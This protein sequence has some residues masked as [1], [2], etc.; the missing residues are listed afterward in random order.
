MK[1]KKVKETLIKNS[2]MFVVGI[3]LILLML[4]S[5]NELLTII[6]PIVFSEM[7]PR[8]YSFSHKRYSEVSSGSSIRKSEREE[9]NEDS[10]IYTFYLIYISLLSGYFIKEYFLVSNSFENVF[11]AF[12]TAIGIFCF[13]II[14]TGTVANKIYR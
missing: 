4:M 12:I 10:A 6:I 2:V 1:W 9:I 5:G 3:I 11:L 13:L 8:L 14:V 7:I